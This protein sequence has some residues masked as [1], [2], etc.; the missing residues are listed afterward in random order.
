M[1]K[2]IFLRTWS[3][4][5]KKSLVEKFIFYAGAIDHLEMSHLELCRYFEIIVDIVEIINLTHCYLYTQSRSFRDER[6]H[7][8]E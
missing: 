4:L 8:Q 1:T 6:L 7:L 5:L 2:Y 3:H